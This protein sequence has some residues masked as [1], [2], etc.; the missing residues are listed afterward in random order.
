MGKTE[1]RQQLLAH[2]RDVFAKRGYHEAS[3]DDIAKAAGVARGTFYLYFAD[4]R[5]IFEELVD[6]MFAKLGMAIMRVDPDKPV[7]EQVRE[8]IRRIIRTLLDDR[9]TTRILLRDAVGLDKDFDRKLLT[10]Y[11]EACNLLDESLRDGQKLG[12]V[13]EGDTRMFAYLTV[14]ALK[15]LLYQVVMRG[16]DMSEERIEEELYRFLRG[17]YL[18]TGDAPASARA[19]KKRR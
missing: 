18:R 3:I 13:L 8:N 6:R 14:G 10:F 12:I 19:P 5:T 1:R 2:A 7:E 17:G 16:W 15:E 4:K 9:A 11:D